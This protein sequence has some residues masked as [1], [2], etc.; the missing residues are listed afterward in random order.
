LLFRT[1]STRKPEFV[2]RSDASMS[3]EN[4]ASEKSSGNEVSS[5][6]AAACGGDTDLPRKRPTVSVKRALM[7]G[8]SQKTIRRLICRGLL[9]PSRAVRHLLIPRGEIDR[10]L[11]ETTSS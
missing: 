4:H 11:K 3:A 1:V 10:F 6:Q 8:L 5:N 2:S 9:R 7:L